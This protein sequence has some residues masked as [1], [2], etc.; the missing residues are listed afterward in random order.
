MNGWA[1]Y[2]F[3]GDAEP[4]DTEGQGV[5]GVWFTFTPEGKKAQ[6]VADTNGGW[7]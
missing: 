5:G 7:H 3:A 2:R 4:G 6:A 1:A